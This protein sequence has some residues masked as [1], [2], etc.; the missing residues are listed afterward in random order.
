MADHVNPTAIVASDEYAFVTSEVACAATAFLVWDTLINLDREVEYIWSGPNS[1]VKWTFLLIRHIPYLIQGS[2]LTLVALSGHVWQ[3]RQCRAWIIY[4]LVAIEALIIAVEVVLIVRIYA[5]YSR[6]RAVL[7]LV[8]TLFCAEI[9]AMCTVL[10]IS[11]PKITFTTQCLITS[12]PALFPTYWT[13]S[14]AFE[15]SLFTLTLIKFMN[16]VVRTQLSRQSI[17]FVLMRDGTWAYAIIFAVMLLNTLMYQIE[18]NTLA[19]IC[20]FWEIAVMSFAGSHVL[21]NLRQ[22]AVEP[23]DSVYEGSSADGFSPARTRRL[24]A[25]RFARENTDITL[26]EMQSLPRVEY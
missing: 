10:A 22:L 4:Q 17:L 11:I 24:S 12:T 3:P 26:V 6:N 23:R 13:I 16:N 9:G 19:G 15:T 2:V 14:L 18:R 21:L 7:L 5:M 8:L 25:M 20:Y 1:W